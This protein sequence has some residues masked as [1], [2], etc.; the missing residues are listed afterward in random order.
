MGDEIKQLWFNLNTN[1][2]QFYTL[3]EVLLY[4]L[5]AFMIL[6][7]KQIK[8]WDSNWSPWYVNIV[9]WER[10]CLKKHCNI[11]LYYL[12]YCMLTAKCHI[13][14]WEF[15][16]LTLLYL[17]LW[18]QQSRLN[19]AGGNPE[20]WWRQGRPHH[21]SAATW[22]Q[23]SRGRHIPHLSDRRTNPLPADWTVTANDQSTRR[24]NPNSRLI[25]KNN[26]KS[27]GLYNL[28]V[29]WLSTIF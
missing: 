9:V 7:H 22:R 10:A 21:S 23:D 29:V 5:S 27:I 8:R 14:L 15:F 17:W 16:F 2:S 28:F 4:V 3:L 11:H 6:L 13:I 1:L 25:H 12:Q 18:L 19:W 26:S 24:V 20:L